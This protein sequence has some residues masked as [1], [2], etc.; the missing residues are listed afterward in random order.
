MSTPL[1]RII[2]IAVRS[3]AGKSHREQLRILQDCAE[4]ADTPQL[5]RSIQS[6]STRSEILESEFR[7]FEATPDEE[8]I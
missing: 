1:H 6:L 8:K 2:E 5:K 4:C 3:A 7:R